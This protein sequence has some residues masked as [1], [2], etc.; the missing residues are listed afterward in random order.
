MAVCV[1]Y[2][3]AI[4]ALPQSNYI[5]K[6]ETPGAILSQTGHIQKSTKSLSEETNSGP[7]EASVPHMK[8]DAAS[9]DKAQDVPAQLSQNIVA[10][11]YNYLASHPGKDFRKEMIRACNFWLNVEAGEL[12]IIESSISMLHNASLL[13]DDIQDNSRLRRGFPVAHDVFGQAQTINSANYMYFLAQQNLMQLPHQAAICKIYNEELLNLHVGQGMDLFWRDSFQAP[14]EE[15]YLGMISNK[16]GGLFRLMVRLMQESSQSEIDLVPL[17]NLLGLLFQVQDDYKNLVSETMTAAKGYCDDLT[18]GKFSFPIIHAIRNSRCANNAVSNVL[19]Q[20]TE[21]TRLK[22]E[23][24]SYMAH[25]TNSFE[26]TKRFV[27]ELLDQI[28]S[29]L[30]GL[31]PRNEELEV[32]LRKLSGVDVE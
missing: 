30:K 28:D 16:T 8:A 32:A 15:E 13:I 10:A 31:E 3:I 20:R 27:R 22:E 4:H 18:E 12:E 5:F 23:A 19:R 24:V 9:I 1:D 11:P 2:E 29:L 26:Y 7:V 6:H 25:V 21:A 14:T 17:A